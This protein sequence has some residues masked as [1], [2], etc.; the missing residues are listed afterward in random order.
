MIKKLKSFE[1]VFSSFLHNVCDISI[2]VFHI[3]QECPFYFL[4]MICP[5]FTL[6]EYID[7]LTE[8]T[9]RFPLS[10]FFSS[11]ST[12]NQSEGNKAL[13]MY[14]VTTFKLKECVL[15]FDIL[16]MVSVCASYAFVIVGA[17]KKLSF[18]FLP[19]VESDRVHFNTRGDSKQEYFNYL[20]IHF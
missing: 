3:L 16:R 7:S 13:S 12:V 10:L 5:D 6:I 19:V 14:E 1:F 20:I 11:R 2:L 4:P 17:W 9:R 15:R 18:Y 8:S